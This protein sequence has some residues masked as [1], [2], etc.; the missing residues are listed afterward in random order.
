VIG[1]DFAFRILQAITGMRDELKS[2]LLNLQ[3]LEFIY[4]KSLFPE[5]EYMFKHAL[6]QEVAYNSLLQKRRKEIHENIG[7]AIEAI[8]ADKLEQFYEMLAYHYSG[9]ENLEKALQF[10]QLAA[11]K[12]IKNYSNLE[13]YRFCEDATKTLDQLP[14]TEENKRK[15]IDV[16]NLMMIPMRLVGHPEGSLGLLEVGETIAGELGDRRT[17]SKVYGT[18]SMNYLSR[19]DLKTALE[20]AENCYVEACETREV[21]LMAPAAVALCSVLGFQGRYSRVSDTVTEALDLLEKTTREPDFFGCPF[22]P[23][24]ELLGW[25]GLSVGLMGSFDEAMPIFERG[26]SFAKKINQRLLQFDI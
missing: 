2:H 26:L 16:L 14:A 1:R 7:M 12:A 22:N 19:G 10:T 6:T 15:L 25:Y 5:L 8:Y 20:Y 17:L 3:G 23:Y 9:S 18:L 21:E 24:S 11:E 13:A 4:E